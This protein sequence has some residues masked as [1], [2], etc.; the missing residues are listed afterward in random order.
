MLLSMKSLRGYRVR[1]E[2]SVAGT[3][4]DFLF[5]DDSWTVRRMLVDTGSILFR[6]EKA[7]VEARFLG[8]PDW[9]ARVLP[10][11]LPLARISP[12][13][14]AR[15]PVGEPEFKPKGARVRG[16]RDATSQ[17]QGGRAPEFSR[18]DGLDPEGGATGRERRRGRP[19]R[20]QGDHRLPNRRGGRLRRPGPRLHR[21]RRDLVDTL[22]RDRHRAL[23]S[24][25]EGARD[26][27]LDRGDD[28]GGQ[29]RTHRPAQSGHR[30]EPPLRALGPGQPR[31]RGPPLRL[32]RPPE[33]LALRGCA[34]FQQGS[35]DI[36]PVPHG[37]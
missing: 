4:R 30:R 31:A 19:P 14:S 16:S 12:P 35:K 9:E 11:D 1:A 8:H 28:L 24:G 25:E 32:L 7:V 2:D 23:A 10:V 26:P 36:S 18:G 34:A 33:A 29:D 6:G 37:P 20:L 17:R 15:P 5:D 13:R 27:A 22:R 21:R 3:V